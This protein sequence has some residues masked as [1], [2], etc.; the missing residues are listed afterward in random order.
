MRARWR[1]VLLRITI[2]LECGEWLS[3]S[4]VTGFCCFRRR[5]RFF[6]SEPFATAS[7]VISQQEVWVLHTP[8]TLEFTMHGHIVHT[9]RVEK[10]CRW[11]A[12]ARVTG[13]TLVRSC[14]FR[15]S[16]ALHVSTFPALSW[17]GVV[18]CPSLEQPRLLWESDKQQTIRVCM[19]W[20][21]SVRAATHD[22]Y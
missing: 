9:S 2:I 14:C 22:D 5:L 17:R 8:R 11:Q 7:R 16:V 10:L 21:H 6:D 13:H 19:W 18:R 4:L 12:K 15:H 1:Y 3:Y 20:K